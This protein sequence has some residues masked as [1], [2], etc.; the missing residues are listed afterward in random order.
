MQQTIG[1]VLYDTHKASPIL[2]SSGYEIKITR[3]PSGGKM[4]ELV[5]ETFIIY[6]TKKRNYFAY[7]SCPKKKIREILPLDDDDVTQLLMLE[8]RPDLVELYLGR[9]VLEA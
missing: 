6:R 9:K 3:L 4:P 2:K 7:V 1:M 8:N 5:L